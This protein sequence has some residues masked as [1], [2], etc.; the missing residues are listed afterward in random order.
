LHQAILRFLPP[1]NNPQN[2][3]TARRTA[4]FP[5]NICAGF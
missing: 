3:A 1:V 2:L 4:A 5:A